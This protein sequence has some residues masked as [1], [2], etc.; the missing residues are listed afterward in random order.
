MVSAWQLK[1][2]ELEI[3]EDNKEGKRFANADLE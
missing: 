1:Q 3:T 2:S